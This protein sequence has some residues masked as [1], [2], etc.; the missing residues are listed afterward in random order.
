MSPDNFS[1]V[2]III[3][4]GGERTAPVC[5]HLISEVVS[6]ERIEVVQKAP[7]T[8]A[9]QDSFGK[10]IEMDR[11]WT[12]SLDGDILPS[13]GGLGNLIEFAERQPPQNLVCLGMVIDK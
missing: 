6:Q 13:L 2:G 4:S 1:E 9:L 11:K 12:L 8:A 3:R 7:F 5:R 10:G